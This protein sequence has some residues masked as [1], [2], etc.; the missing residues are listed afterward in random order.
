ML[1]DGVFNDIG[2]DFSRVRD[3]AGGGDAS[4]FQIRE[5]RFSTFEGHDG[6]ITLDHGHPEVIDYTVDVLCHWLDR[7]A[8]GRR[9]DAAYAVPERFWATV[10]P[11]VRAEFPRAWFV[12][13]VIH[14]DY[15]GLVRRA[16][17]DSLTQYELW[18]AVWSRLNDANF[19]SSTGHS[20]GIMHFWTPSC[21]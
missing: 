18:K 16:G 9:L 10:L 19:T 17:F 13:E 12:G 1:L 6:L 2:T 4:W 5:G 11:R 20:L 8:V 7:G 14:G 3:A 21:R 15:S